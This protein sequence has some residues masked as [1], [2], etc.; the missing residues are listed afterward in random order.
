M[1]TDKVNKCIENVISNNE[2]RTAIERRDR[3][4]N[5][6]LDSI[7]SKI[8]RRDVDSNYFS[9]IV[10]IGFD[11]IQRIDNSNVREDILVDISYVLNN[12][13]GA[14]VFNIL[15]VVFVPEL[16]DPRKSFQKG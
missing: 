16:P 11:Y 14:E 10:R 7:Y 9:M 6:T 2:I 8:I 13:N 3:S 15:N 12:A 4:N 1:L 5:Y